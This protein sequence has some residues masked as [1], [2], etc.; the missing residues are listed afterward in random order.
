LFRF[1]FPSTLRQLDQTGTTETPTFHPT[2]R[3]STAV[4]SALYFICAAAAAAAAMAPL[5]I[6]DPDAVLPTARAAPAPRPPATRGDLF[7]LI[8]N[9]NTSRCNT[10][11]ASQECAQVAPEPAVSFAETQATGFLQ[12]LTFPV[13]FFFFLARRPW[14]PS[15]HPSTRASAGAS[16]ALLLILGAEFV[17]AVSVGFATTMVVCEEKNYGVALTVMRDGATGARNSVCDYNAATVTAFAAGSGSETVA[18]AVASDNRYTEG[19]ETFVARRENVTPVSGVMPVLN[20][21]LR[22]Q[23]LAI[24]VNM[25]SFCAVSIWHKFRSDDCGGASTV[26]TAKRFPSPNWY[27]QKTNGLWPDDVMAV[28]AIRRNPGVPFFMALFLSFCLYPHAMFMT[29]AMALIAAVSLSVPAESPRP[30]RHPVAVSH[31]RKV[32]VSLLMPYI[33]LLLCCRVAGVEG[34]APP[35]DGDAGFGGNPTGVS[36]GGDQ[37]CGRIRQELVCIGRGAGGRLGTGV[38]DNR[39]DEPGEVSVM[40]PI[41][42]AELDALAQVSAGAAHTCV[43]FMSGGI[44][45]FGDGGSGRLGTGSTVSIGDQASEL[46]T[47]PVIPFADPTIP[48][49]QVSSGYVHTCVL[50]ANGGVRCFGDGGSGQLGAGSFARIGDDVGEMATLSFIAF[51]KPTVVATQVTAGGYHTCVLFTNGCVRCFGFGSSGRLGTGS[52][53]SVG[54]SLSQ[55]E[56]LPF[57]TFQEPTIIAT[58]VSAGGSHTCVLF[59]NGGV[60]CFGNGGSGRLGTGSTVSIGDQAGELETL[61]VIPFAQSTIPATQ[62]SSGDAHTCVLFANGGVR[63]FGDNS[64]GQLGTGADSDIGDGAGEVETLPFI[65]FSEPTVVAIQVSVGS[66]HTCLLFANSEIRCLGYGFYGQLGTGSTGNVGGS[67][68]QPASLDYIPFLSLAANILIPASGH[69]SGGETLT[70]FGNGFIGTKDFSLRFSPPCNGTVPLFKTG[71]ALQASATHAIVTTP[72]F[73]CGP[74]TTIAV[75]VSRD[76]GLYTE[77]LPF[78]IYDTPTVTSIAPNGGPISGGLDITVFGA[79]LLDTNSTMCRFGRFMSPAIG[80]SSSLTA[81]ICVSPSVALPEVLTLEIALNGRNFTSNL[82]SFFLFDAVTVSIG[83]GP[84]TGAT[85]LIVTLNGTLP[86]LPNFGN[87]VVVRFRSSKL[88]IETVASLD[89]I[90]N[91][92]VCT[93]PDVTAYDAD[94]FFPHTVQ[95]RVVFFEFLFL[96]DLLW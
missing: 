25:P 32:T 59:A 5:A 79:N 92:I 94:N 1:F 3:V 42:F 40:E 62:V 60:R 10:T 48:A 96:H 82:S 44:R 68:A 2:M 12:S 43:L 35:S 9:R 83:L 70:V 23:T 6:P 73:P 36:A 69:I 57:I 91:T 81:V 34:V 15:R 33:T 93:T 71:T 90:S 22:P 61:P 11:V 64:S 20:V 88:S 28:V 26:W 95:V 66:Y 58:Q 86:S 24:Y 49:L 39:G 29:A 52:T 47:L 16:L 51:A 18:V 45:C 63:C 53:A 65:S 31:G 55:M 72:P 89:R 76:Y 7:T 78:V 56:T 67:G 75:S 27:Q 19:G 54:G 38:A 8:C 41:V 4:F 13:F 37:T 74:N 46:K 84:I 50:F 85:P 14:K 21:P 80:F 87:S 30:A 17:Q 77:P